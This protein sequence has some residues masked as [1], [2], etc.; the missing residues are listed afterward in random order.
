M[1]AGF[2]A[3][4]SALFALACTIPD[5]RFIT[6]MLVLAFLLVFVNDQSTS[7][8]AR[9]GRPARHGAP[10]EGVHGACHT[11]PRRGRRPG[12]GRRHGPPAGGVSSGR[13]SIHARPWPAK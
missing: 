10:P 5:N 12:V 8:P 4:S 13:S 2:S 6:L 11:G 9:R 1:S 7:G 3:L